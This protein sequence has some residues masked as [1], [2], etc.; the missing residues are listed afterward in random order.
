VPK[1][2]TVMGME[3]WPCAAVLKILRIAEA[4]M[5]SVGCFIVSPVHELSLWCG[6]CSMGA[7]AAHVT[8]P[9][10]DGNEWLT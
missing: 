9:L 2:L 10:R 5:A 7:F 8:N 1:P 4:V 3:S 6:L